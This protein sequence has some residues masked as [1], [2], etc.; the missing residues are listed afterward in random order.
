MTYASLLPVIEYVPGS[1]TLLV[2][3]SGATLEEAVEDFWADAEELL[4]TPQPTESTT[5]QSAD[6]PLG[7]E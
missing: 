7:F 3:G 5:P 4:G 1:D 6:S 2:V